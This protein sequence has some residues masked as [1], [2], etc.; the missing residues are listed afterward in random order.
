MVSV[1]SDSSRIPSSTSSCRPGFGTCSIRGPQ[2]QWHRRGNPAAGQ[3]EHGATASFGSLQVESP[4]L[5][6]FMLLGVSP[7]DQL[8]AILPRAGQ[9]R[10]P[11]FWACFLSSSLSFIQCPTVDKL[12]SVV[13]RWDTVEGDQVPSGCGHHVQ[14]VGLI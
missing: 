7:E 5:A 13:L 4:C 3:R 12:T 8:P 10:S 14:S 9:S 11:G 1:P 6:V 2:A